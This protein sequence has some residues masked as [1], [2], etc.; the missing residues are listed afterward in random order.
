MFVYV[1]HYVHHL[2]N[3]SL[4]PWSSVCLAKTCSILYLVL[5]HLDF[6]WMY[7]LG[8]IGLDTIVL[9]YLFEV[10]NLLKNIFSFGWFISL[11][12]THFDWISVSSNRGKSLPDY[13]NS[14][15]MEVILDS[16]RCNVNASGSTWLDD[17]SF[18]Y[19]LTLTSLGCKYMTLYIYIFIY[20]CN[21]E[22]K[23]ACE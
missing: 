22:T 8:W 2:L 10:Y 12:G 9:V 16:F 23:G 3:L 13:W 18:L 21:G 11:C 17:S 5:W 19:L 14:S 1:Y 6:I 7:L 4:F 20:F 15:V